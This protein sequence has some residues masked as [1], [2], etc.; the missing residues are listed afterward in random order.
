L[1]RVEVRGGNVLNFA[2]NFY[3]NSVLINLSVPTSIIVLDL[4]KCQKD[5]AEAIEKVNTDIT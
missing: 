4:S 3:E 5:H 1:I 2:V